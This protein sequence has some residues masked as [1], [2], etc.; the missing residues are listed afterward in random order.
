VVETVV[1]AA[2]VGI[3]DALVMETKEEIFELNNGCVCCTGKHLQQP[4]SVNP[5]QHTLA[6]RHPCGSF[7]AQPNTFLT[8]RSCAHQQAADRNPTTRSTNTHSE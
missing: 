4:V 7:S 2:Q 6:H 8:Q 3:D 1:T 5:T